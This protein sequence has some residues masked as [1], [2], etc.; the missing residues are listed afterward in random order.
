MKKILVVLLV[1]IMI[2]S[3]LMLSFSGCALTDKTQE[4]GEDI[5]DSYENISEEAGEV[6]DNVIEKKEKAEETIEDLKNAAD[7]L[8]E[9]ADAVKEIT[10]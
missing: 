9:A 10:D 6:Y 2:F 1:G 8:G 3:T 7:E 5:V 4:I